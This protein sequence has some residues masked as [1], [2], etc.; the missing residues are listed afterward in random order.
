MTRH[1]LDVV[2]VGDDR[3]D[4]VVVAVGGDGRRIALMFGEIIRAPHSLPPVPLCVMHWQTV[5]GRARFD[6]NN[7]NKKRNA[8][9]ER[10]IYI[11]TQ[12]EFVRK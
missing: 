3:G 7:N 6:N 11:S 9:H 1:S 4:I 12:P 2:C 5:C 10:N 8:K